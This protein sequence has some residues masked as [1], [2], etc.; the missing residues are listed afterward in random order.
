[1]YREIFL[2][3]VIFF[4]LGTSYVEADSEVYGYIIF[5]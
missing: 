2:L 4:L 3:M 1:M 5:E